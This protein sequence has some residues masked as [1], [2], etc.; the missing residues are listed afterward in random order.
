MNLPNQ[1]M[2]KLWRPICGAIVT[3]G[4]VPIFSTLTSHFSSFKA[5]SDPQVITPSASLSPASTSEFSTHSN[6]SDALVSTTTSSV[7]AELNSLEQ[8]NRQRAEQ[9][10]QEA[11]NSS[12]PSEASG[13]SLSNPSLAILYFHT[14]QPKPATH[15]PA[16]NPALTS[17]P[18]PKLKYPI[19]LVHGFLGYDSLLKH[20][21]SNIPL[22]EYFGTVRQHLQE[23]GNYVIV[24]ILPKAWSVQRRA[25][26]LAVAI[27]IAP[28]TEKGAG[29][30]DTELQQQVT[31]QVPTQHADQQEMKAIKENVT[32][33]SDVTEHDDLG[34][35]VITDGKVDIARYKGPF[36]VIAHSMGGLD[37]RFLTTHLQQKYN[38]PSY[39]NRILSLTTLS[40]PHHGSPVAD[41]LVQQVQK[42]RQLFHAPSFISPLS[43]GIPALPSS[44]DLSLSISGPDIAASSSLTI[45]S[46]N[47][48]DNSANAATDCFETLVEHFSELFNIDFRGM[49]DLTTTAC[50]S[51]NENTPNVEGTHYFSYAACR[52]FKAT[53]IFFITSKIV[54]S[55]E[56]WNDGLVSAESGKWGEVVSILPMDHLEMVG[57]GLS[58]KVTF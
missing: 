10:N 26:V 55:Q 30:K 32:P 53:D 27:G 43:D 41:L 11:V 28:T 9:A 56:G 35:Y 25:Q 12:T 3:F 47:L 14:T 44:H 8:E 20:P 39:P 29:P 15:D 48:V 50:K 33:S 19:V 36:H 37:A 51:F 17:T 45:S 24:P 46:A 58:Q 2:K 5:Q 57:L 21:I 49:L 16:S 34:V 31:K 38:S 13:L 6:P 22:F 52:E 1:A 40:T 23:A 7:N 42:R 18:L 54:E 4:C